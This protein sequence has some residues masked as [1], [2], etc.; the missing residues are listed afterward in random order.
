[1]RGIIDDNFYVV[2][3]TTG[4]PGG[5][6]DIILRSEDGYTWA[7]VPTGDFSAASYGL[8]AI[9]KYVGKWW[10]TRATGLYFA[11]NYSGPYELVDLESGS[12]YYTTFGGYAV[13]LVRH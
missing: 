12:D 10:I 2:G 7:I 13:G 9:K 11:D 5:D 6:T 4:K 1:M 8:S 3:Y